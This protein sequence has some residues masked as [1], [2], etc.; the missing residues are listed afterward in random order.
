MT[1]QQQQI[2]E[3]LSSEGWRVVERQVKPSWWLDEVWVIESTRSPVGSRA[4]VSFLVDPQS[5]SLRDTGAQVWAVCISPEGPA[6]TAFGT[7]VVPLRPNWEKLRRREF[8]E[9]IRALRVRSDD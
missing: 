3:M 6:I 5:L 2:D 8:L 7:D 9:K 4:Y 1:R